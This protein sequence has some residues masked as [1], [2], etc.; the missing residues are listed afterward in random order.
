MADFEVQGQVDLDMDRPAKEVL[1]YIAGVLSDKDRDCTHAVIRVGDSLLTI[2]AVDS[3]SL[4]FIEEEEELPDN[5][6]CIESARKD[7]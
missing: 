1:R 3:G 5:V 4:N 2:S 6:F 7:H